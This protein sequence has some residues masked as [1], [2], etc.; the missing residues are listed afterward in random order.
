MVT[1]APR[2]F[3]LAAAFGIGLRFGLGPSLTS[4]SIRLPIRLA[5]VVSVARPGSSDGGSAPIAKRMTCARALLASALP[6]VAAD[7]P[8]SVTASRPRTPV[9]RK[10]IRIALCLLLLMLGPRRAIRRMRA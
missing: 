7:V 5:D 8:T 3:Q 6:V 4:G 10:R 2:T 9:H 1:F